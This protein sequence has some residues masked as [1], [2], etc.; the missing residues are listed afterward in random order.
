MIFH[1]GTTGSEREFDRYS[2]AQD[3]QFDHAKFAERKERFLPINRSPE[4]TAAQERAKELRTRLASLEDWG[5][6]V[7]GWASAWRNNGLDV[8]AVTVA[9]DEAV[10]AVKSE[11][12]KVLA[13]QME[14][15]VEINNLQG[16]K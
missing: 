4:M 7:A 2:E 11:Q 15:G 1:T 3:Q 14:V 5:R 13:S 16:A 8:P 6:T 12:V 10:R 9:L